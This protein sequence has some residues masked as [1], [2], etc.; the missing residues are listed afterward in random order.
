MSTETKVGAFVIV[1]LLILCSAIYYVR[2][3][4]TVRG[5]VPYRTYFC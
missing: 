2:T 1:S 4:R 5:E 3:T